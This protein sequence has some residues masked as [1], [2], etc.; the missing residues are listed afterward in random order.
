M[1]HNWMKMTIGLDHEPEVIALTAQLGC[2]I[3][4]VLG[5][6]YRLWGWAADH[7]H[8]DATSLD[9]DA[10]GVTYDWIDEFVRLEGFANA[11]SKVC[12]LRSKKN[13][14]VLPKVGKYIGAIAKVKAGNALRQSNHRAKKSRS[15][16]TKGVT[17]PVTRSDKSRGDKNK[18]PRKRD[19]IWDAVCLEFGFDKITPSE[20]TRIGKI[21]RDLKIKEATPA[22]IKLRGDSY[23]KK[24][25]N[26]AYTPE[27][28]VKHWDSLKAVKQ[29]RDIA[30]VMHERS[31]KLRAKERENDRLATLES[32]ER[33]TGA[34]P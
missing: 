32:K 4:T 25:P 33:R 30:D 34:K 18:I 3:D 8:I 21:V 14:I 29:Q 6:L 1:P 11:L 15:T 13:G 5:K 7:C 16:V 23:R 19:E 28:L 27:A 20:Q 24:F 26:C 31:E 9:G 2:D 12:W 22:A 10:I 17:Q